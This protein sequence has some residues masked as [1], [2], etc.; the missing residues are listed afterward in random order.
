MKPTLEQVIAYAQSD[1]DEAK[2]PS[3]YEI[4]LTLAAALVSSGRYAENSDAA[5]ATAWSMVIPFYQGQATYLQLG[6]T[7]FDIQRHASQP[8]GSMHPT[9][10]RAYATGGETGDV[11]EANQRADASFNI[12]VGVGPLARELTPEQ[13]AE[14]NQK[15]ADATSKATKTWIAYRTAMSELERMPTDSPE[16]AKRSRLLRAAKKAK[17]AHVK[18]AKEQSAAYL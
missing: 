14:R 4:A 8:E 6:K 12:T 15:I 17:A 13:V 5:M 10:G 3:P 1:L 7:L 16:T 9:E 18:A 11:G 2:P